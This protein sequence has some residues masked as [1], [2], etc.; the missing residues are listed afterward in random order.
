M[1][2]GENITPGTS[3]DLICLPTDVLTDIANIDYLE[4]LVDNQTDH[5]YHNTATSSQANFYFI[6][7]TSLN[8]TTVE[9]FAVFNDG[10]RA[11]IVRKLLIIENPP[12]VRSPVHQVE[13]DTVFL[14]W[15]S[16][17]TYFQDTTYIVTI[18]GTNSSFMSNTTDFN[19][20]VFL[21][22]STC[23]NCTVDT[24]ATNEAG[25]GSVASTFL[26]GE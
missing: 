10:S 2:I 15:E 12:L 18:H 20:P 16:P 3:K 13:N 26:L 6:A 1:F 8:S 23:G 9:C 19:F 17:N 24:T 21:C 11:L 5:D 25:S 4:W 22:P 7:N 14:S